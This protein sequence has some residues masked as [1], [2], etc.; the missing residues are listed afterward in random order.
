MK[1]A[2]RCRTLRTGPEKTDA[3]HRPVG[4]PSEWDQWPGEA[5]SR[6]IEK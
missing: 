1:T 2:E 6:A 3:L 5:G 4:D